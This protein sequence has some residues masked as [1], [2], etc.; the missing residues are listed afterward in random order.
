MTGSFAPDL[1]DPETFVRDNTAVERPP[2]VPEIALH[3]ASEVVP[4]WQ[5]T[6]KELAESGLPPPFWAFA[7]AGG[8]ALARY[9]LDHPAQ[10][11]G[12]RVLDFA[13]GSGIQGIAALKAGAAAVEAAEI[14]RFAAAALGLNAALNGV[15]LTVVEADL[16]G[17]PNPGWEVVLAGDVCYEQ[18]TAGRIEDW[19]RRLA[20]EGALVLMGDPGRSYLPGEGLERLAAYSVKT[21][22]EL[23]DTDLRNAVVWRVLP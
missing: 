22:R 19:L 20:A 4:L 9:L 12:R 10:V 7:W 21:S 17:R 15:M 14:D 6:E 3:L 11:A 16:I 18:P 2:L 23:E 5:S 8:Q 13:A 1:G